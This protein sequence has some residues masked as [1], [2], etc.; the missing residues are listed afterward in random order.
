LVEDMINF[1]IRNNC[2]VFIQSKT[3]KILRK[4]AL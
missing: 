4:T 1:I 2:K 3:S